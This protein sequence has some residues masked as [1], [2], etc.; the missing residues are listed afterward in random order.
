MNTKKAQ[1]ATEYLIILAVVV[2]ISL[3][4]IGVL[5][6]IPSIGGG[7][8]Q[9]SLDSYWRTA[10]IGVVYLAVGA[11]TTSISADGSGSI[12]L[13][14]N[15]VDTITIT[16]VSL[17]DSTTGNVSSN[18]TTMVLSAGQQGSLTYSDLT[19]S[20]TTGASYSYTLMVQYTDSSTGA[21]YSFTGDDTKL[22]GKIAQSLS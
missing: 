11:A 7:A 2:V 20:G 4:V 8:K 5:G 16:N 9:T 6:G 21:V 18:T 1:T 3:I 12:S 10:D 15:K 19:N 17:T 13:R 14:N 22:E